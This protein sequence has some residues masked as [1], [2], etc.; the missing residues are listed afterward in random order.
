MGGGAPAAGN[1][2]FDFT[3]ASSPEQ[4]HYAAGGSGGAP[5]AAATALQPAVAT[6]SGLRVQGGAKKWGP[7]R[8]DATPVSPPPPGVCV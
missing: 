4:Q 1:G 5:A 8:F 3:G 2:L 6:G 7:A